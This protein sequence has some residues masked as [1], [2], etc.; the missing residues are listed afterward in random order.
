MKT[1]FKI[2]NRIQCLYPWSE[3]RVGRPRCSVFVGAVRKRVFLFLGLQSRLQEAEMENL[4]ALDQFCLNLRY[5]ARQRNSDPEL[6]PKEVEKLSRGFIRGKRPLGLL[7]NEEANGDE[8]A[9][10]ADLTG[11]EPDTLRVAP[12]YHEEPLDLQNLRFLKSEIEHGHHERVAE[13]IGVTKFQ[14][15]RWGEKVKAPHPNN[16]RKLLKYHGIDPDIDLKVV[17]LFLSLERISGF[18]QKRW[19]LQRLEELPVAEVT[20]FYPALRRILRRNEKG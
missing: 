1:Q 19:L 9:A 10:I 13:A 12:L 18:A 5:L 4:T 11:I 17:P 7:M 2:M 15:S 3:S 20:A 6:W 16:V 14:L 8:V